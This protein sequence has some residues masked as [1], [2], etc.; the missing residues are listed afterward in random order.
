MIE[1]KK[2]KGRPRTRELRPGDRVPLS[3][4]VTPETKA[5]LDKTAADSGRSQSQE[6]EMRLEQS[7]EGERM[8]QDI[9][10]LL[11]RAKEHEAVIRARALEQGQ[12]AVLTEHELDSRLDTHLRKFTTMLVDRGILPMRVNPPAP[13]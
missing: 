11:D 8:L 4:R 13:S 9:E 2:K 5:K 1:P 7:F 6:A 3:L 10:G 12:V